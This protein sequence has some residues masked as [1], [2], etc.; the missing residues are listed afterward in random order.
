METKNKKI[1]IVEDEV[2]TAELLSRMLMEQKA[3]MLTAGSLKEA[4]EILDKSPVDL[5]ILDRIL[6]DGDGVELLMRMKKTPSL[7]QVPVLILSGKGKE[8]DQVAG[9]DLGADDYMTK[10][11]SVE[12]LR[13]RVTALLRR[14]AK[15][16]TLS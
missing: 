6:P 3:E 14:A 12:E 11:F 9:L 5:V 7:K 13:A 4:R 10:P 1:L 15:F 16:K 2:M 8:L